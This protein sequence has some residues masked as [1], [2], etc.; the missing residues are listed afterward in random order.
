V[1]AC[2]YQ[3]RQIRTAAISGGLS[4]TVIGSCPASDTRLRRALEAARA[5]TL[6]ELS[7]G[8]GAYLAVVQR[9]LARGSDQPYETLVF[10]DLGGASRVHLARY[11]GGI[12]WATS[13]TAL[14]ALVESRPVLEQLT[15]DVVASGIE[16]CGGQAPFNEVDTV[17]PGSLLVL[18]PTAV[19]TERWHVPAPPTT[20]EQAGPG[21]AAAL[22]E[23]VAARCPPGARL[24]ADV[25]TGVDS[26]A[27]LALAAQSIDPG[28]RLIALTSISD[29]DER[30]LDLAA[31]I[32]PTHP[33]VDHELLDDGR[34]AAYFRDL[35]QLDRL[36]ATDLPCRGIPVMGAARTRLERAAERGATDYLTGYA[37]DNI[38]SVQRRLPAL[39]ATR[40][41]RA[42]LTPAIQLAS[43]RRGSAT[44]AVAAVLRRHPVD[45]ARSLRHTAGVIR[46]GGLDP[47]REPTAF[48]DGVDPVSPT[49]ASG[50]LTTGAAD[51]I[52]DWF[53]REAEACPQ[54]HDPEAACDWQGLRDVVS[55]LA[56]LRNLGATLGVEVH[57]PFTDDAVLSV[58]EALSFRREPPET[59]KPLVTVAMRGIVPHAV[60]GRRRKDNLG[61][62]YT[63]DLGLR[64]NRDGLWQVF[65][66]SI[67]IDRR[68]FDRSAVAASFKRLLGGTELIGRSLRGFFA[69]ETYLATLD[70]QRSSW[71]KERQ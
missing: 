44:A 21:F 54:G 19:A 69:V 65:D 5:R 30:D 3:D 35:D 42:A 70:L 22:G 10:G 47:A 45:R 61:V 64:I 53:D 27:I 12:M 17:E 18:G 52:A 39:I 31:A 41:R 29:R 63:H 25:S 59:F 68:I 1:W 36:P 11:R 51:V 8:F 62:D 26:T 33:N 7:P 67:L 20:L 71:W 46:A 58:W 24:A 16:L 23:G 43:E 48:R 28:E 57:L 9:P 55:T 6:S 50:W 15:L 13:A 14:A 56:C 40:G 32:A 37:G 38:L 34:A 49:C 4:M 66:S 60:T 2:G